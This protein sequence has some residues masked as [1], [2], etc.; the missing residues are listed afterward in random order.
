MGQELF[1]AFMTRVIG[2]LK[3]G[4]KYRTAEIYST[5]RNSFQ[6]FLK[7][8][9]I[10]SRKVTSALIVQYE[11]WLDENGVTRN[12]SS[13]YMR[14]LR[15]VYN[16]AVERGMAPTGEPFKQVYTGVDKTRK[17]AVSVQVIRRMKH[18]DLHE[19]HHLAFARDLFLFSFYTRGM[20]FVDMSYLRPSNIQGGYLSYVRRKTGQTI[21]IKWEPCMQEI[22]DRYP[23]SACGNL[24]PII[25]HPDLNDRS[26]Y[27]NILIPVNSGLAEISRMLHVDPPI[28]TYVA[29]HSWASIA[30]SRNVPVSI[31]SEAMGHDSER[32]TRIYLASV[33]NR[34]VDKANSM[35][36]DLV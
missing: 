5:T 7:G 33:S 17:R 4:K 16:R 10:Y 27:R 14:V 13:F 34:K 22:V 19:K 11:R 6:R 36:M 9:D 29:R 32:T 35:I 1:L 20:S 8:K 3:T 15:A 12:T 23:R 30:Y 21:R 24:L 2:E 31:I 18:L 26:Q 28:T 25:L